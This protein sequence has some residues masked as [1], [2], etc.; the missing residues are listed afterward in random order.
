M[1]NTKTTI[2]MPDPIERFIAEGFDRLKVDGSTPEETT[3]AFQEI[4]NLLAI[5]MSGHHGPDMDDP[6]YFRQ[7]EENAYAWGHARRVTLEAQA[8]GGAFLA[9]LKAA[10]DSPAFELLQ[11]NTR[12]GDES[13]AFDPGGGLKDRRQDGDE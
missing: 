11:E 13:D 4:I 3:E 6:T 9:F 8:V 10:V 12:R 7:M 5:L 1:S 2:I